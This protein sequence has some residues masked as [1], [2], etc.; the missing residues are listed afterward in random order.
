MRMCILDIIGNKM[1]S[2]LHHHI[3]YRVAIFN[4]EQFR[5]ESTYKYT[6]FV[7]ERDVR[8]SVSISRQKFQLCGEMT[9]ALL[10]M[11]GGSGTKWRKGNCCI[12]M[13]MFRGNCWLFVWPHHKI[14][15]NDTYIM[16]MY[17]YKTMWLYAPYDALKV[18]QYT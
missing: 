5:K 14:T 4:I 18:T 7:N 10:H 2:L 16:Y 17:T 15:Y 6:K 9:F 1:T 3:Y 13:Y 12:H 8:E 11:L